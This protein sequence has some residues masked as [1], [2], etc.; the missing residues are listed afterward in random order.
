MVY[1]CI[2]QLEK[3]YHITMMPLAENYS[4]NEHLHITLIVLVNLQ[5]YLPLID[6]M[7]R[8]F[9]INLLEIKRKISS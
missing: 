2:A 7:F 8:L 5:Y 6:S 1:P 9:L 4:S 3:A